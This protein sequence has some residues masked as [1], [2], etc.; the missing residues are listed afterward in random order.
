MNDLPMSSHTRL[1]AG[2][3]TVGMF[4]LLNLVAFHA[5]GTPVWA[6]VLLAAILL[7]AMANVGIERRRR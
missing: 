6:W 2:L 5:R 1:A 3:S 7:P 4:A